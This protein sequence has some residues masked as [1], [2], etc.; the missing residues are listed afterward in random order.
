MSAAFE[1][2]TEIK[3]FNL[4]PAV[5]AAMLI[6]VGLA[7]QFVALKAFAFELE[8]DVRQAFGHRKEDC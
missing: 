7:L 8:I 4:N 2:E 3:G 6:V 5:R 1:A